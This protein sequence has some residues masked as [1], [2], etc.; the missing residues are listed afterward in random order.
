MFHCSALRAF[1]RALHFSCQHAFQTYNIAISLL[2]IT[3]AH[4]VGHESAHPVK[5][6][7]W[8]CML[9]TQ[10]HAAQAGLDHTRYRL[11]TSSKHN[12]GNKRGKQS[13]M[14]PTAT[15]SRACRRVAV[16][17]LGSC[18]C[19]HVQLMIAPMDWSK[20]SPAVP[21]TR[22]THLHQRKLRQ[23]RLQG[24]VGVVDL[25]FTH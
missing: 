25:H 8:K 13:H 3:K 16:T 15:F 10:R 20:A 14:L 23:L 9:R 21:G 18:D 1:K 17:H 19:F 12:Q 6:M 4:F 11:T 2:P 24:Q 22:C 7:R 5:R